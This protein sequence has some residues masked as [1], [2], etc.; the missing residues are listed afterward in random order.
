MERCWDIYNFNILT[1]LQIL[2]IMF[3]QKDKQDD[4]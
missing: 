2:Q 4:Y 1:I 3:R